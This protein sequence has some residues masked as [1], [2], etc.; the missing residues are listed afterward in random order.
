[1]LSLFSM[2]SFM[3]GRLVAIEAIIL[4]EKDGVLPFLKDVVSPF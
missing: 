1:M 2:A 4:S 3:Y